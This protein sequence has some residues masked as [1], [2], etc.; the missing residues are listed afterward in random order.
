MN[1]SNKIEQSMA[2]SEE[3]RP[4]IKEHIHQSST[5]PP[6]TGTRGSQ[7]LAG[8]GKRALIACRQSSEIRA[9]CA[10]ERSY[11]SVRG[12][13]SNDRPYRDRFKPARL[14]KRAKPRWRKLGMICFPRLHWGA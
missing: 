4:L 8:C 13:I 5:R 12:A 3:G 10:N 2:E 7:G 6:P 1:H 11:G 9:V 14:W